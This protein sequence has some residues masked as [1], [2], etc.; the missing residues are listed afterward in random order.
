[1]DKQ[2]VR[3]VARPILIGTA[4]VILLV[5][6]WF[7]GDALSNATEPANHYTLYVMNAD[8]SGQKLLRDEA[9]FDLWSPAWSSDGK[10]IAVSVVKPSGGNG[11]IFVVDAYGQNP[12]QLTQNGQQNYLPSWSHDGKRV[13]YISQQ[14]KDVTT[15]EVHIINADGTDDRTL[16]QNQAQ[17]YGATWSPDDQQIAFGSKRDGNWQ[18][19]LMNADGTNQHPL[20]TSA[21]GS[22]PVWS[23][24]GKWL[25]LT[26]DRDGYDNIYSLTPDGQ[27]QRNLTNSTSVNSNSNWSPD[28]NKIAFWSE[29]DGTANIFV[30][31]RDGSNPVN[32]T[33]NVNMDA[34]SPSWSPNGKQ[35]VFHAALLESGIPALI[36]QNLSWVLVGIMGFV[37]FGIVVGITR[38]KRTKAIQ[39]Q[40]G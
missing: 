10:H 29:R 19:Y 5:I 21:P 40:P 32:L 11:E 33:N 34:Q 12:A 13:V 36:R 20:A 28:G 4:I 22:A 30:M 25:T 17:E 14:A 1:M 6:A 8:G 18:I 31:D 3:S 2:S 27:E 26:S 38:R 7:V 16:T 23:A 15:A 35:I 9:K 37:V 39:R 24:D